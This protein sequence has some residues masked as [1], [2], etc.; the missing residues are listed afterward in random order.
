MG[1][2]K[3]T[4]DLLSVKLPFEQKIEHA[5]AFWGRFE[6]ERPILIDDLAGTGHRRYGELPNMTYLVSRSGQ[7]LFRS[8]WTDPP[9]IEHV[10]R[11]V[12]DS[13]ARRRD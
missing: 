11:Y 1:H 2:A 5:R 13:R 12:V 3:A 9:T 8:D 4:D 6:I 10:L 7:I